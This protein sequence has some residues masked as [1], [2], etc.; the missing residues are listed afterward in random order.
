ME[1]GILLIM[2]GL[3]DLPDGK[4]RTPLSA[5]KTP[6]MDKMAKEGIL[7]MLSPIGKGNVPG[8]DTSHLTLLGYPYWDFYCGRG[9][10]EALG[11]GIKLKEGDVAFRA[12]FATVKNGKILDRRAGRI[13]TEDAHKLAKLLKKVKIAGV[14]VIFANTVEHR[15]VLI[16]RGKGLGAHVSGTDPH[17]LVSVPKSRALKKGSEKTARVLNEFTKK[18]M[19]VLRKAP[20][21]KGREMP[22]NAVLCRGAGTYRKV[23]AFAKKHGVTGACVAGGALYKGVAEYIGMDVLYVKEATGTADTNLK[24][25][26][27]HAAAALKNHD[28]VFVH[29]KATDSCAHDRDFACKKKMIERVDKELIP[30]LK[31][32]GANIMVTGDHTTPCSIGEHTGHEVPLLCWGPGFRK[33]PEKKFDEFSCMGGGLGHLEGWDLF[34]ILVNAMGKGKKVGT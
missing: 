26:A 32:T 19:E 11:S 3:G 25:K 13:S 21:N 8:S 27:K 16:L 7:G 9:P 2:D 10:L 6:N 14:E 30:A 18:A 20:E 34:P 4:G 28:F 31:K 15:G 5:A 22:A 29:V 12:N 17:G 33:D 1:K 24:A 23:E